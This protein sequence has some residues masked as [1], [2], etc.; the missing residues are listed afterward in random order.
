MKSLKR[1]RTLAAQ[2]RWMNKWTSLGL[3]DEKRHRNW[4]RRPSELFDGSCSVWMMNAQH[5]P[6]S[7]KLSHHAGSVKVFG[8]L[9]LP[10]QSQEG[11]SI[12]R[13]TMTQAVALLQQTVVPHHLATLQG[14]I[15]VLLHAEGLGWEIT[16]VGDTG[17]GVWG[18]R[19]YVLDFMV[20]YSQWIQNNKN[21]RYFMRKFSGKLRV[22]FKK[23]V[24]KN[25]FLPVSRCCQGWRHT[26]SSSSR[27]L[28]KQ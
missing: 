12:A 23:H 3:G 20:P 24:P 22:F 28:G 1:M 4:S 21:K 10:V 8:I 26:K 27:C 11:V 9:R 7:F 6:V 15:Q 5:H 17:D 2:Q 14:V 13:C 25:T 19:Y 16:G 18:G